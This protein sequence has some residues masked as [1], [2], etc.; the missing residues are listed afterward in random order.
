VKRIGRFDFGVN[1]Q[2][3]YIGLLRFEPGEWTFTILPC[4]YFGYTSKAMAEKNEQLVAD[5]QREHADG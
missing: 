2:N 1:S 3:L 4:L 5:W